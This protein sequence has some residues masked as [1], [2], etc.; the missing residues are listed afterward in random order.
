MI[1]IAGAHGIKTRMSVSAHKKGRGASEGVDAPQSREGKA[2]TMT[3]YNHIIQQPAPSVNTSALQYRAFRYNHLTPNQR[4]LMIAL[5]R[6]ADAAPGE[7][8]PHSEIIRAI[9]G[10]Y[11]EDDADTRSALHTLVCLTRARLRAVGYAERIVAAWNQGY[12]WE[13]L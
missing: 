2:E 11:A 3:L 12:Y 10:D 8:C 1:T 7:P 5:R 13:A 6:H 9:W 4:R